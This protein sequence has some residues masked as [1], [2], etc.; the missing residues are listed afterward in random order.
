M[1]RKV[2]EVIEKFVTDV[3]EDRVATEVIDLFGSEMDV[4]E[5]FEGLFQAGGDEEVAMRRKVADEELKGGAG[6]KAGL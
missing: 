5:E 2:A 1:K 6:V 4:F 3:A